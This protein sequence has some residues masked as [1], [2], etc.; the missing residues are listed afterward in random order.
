MKKADV[1]AKLDLYKDRPVEVAINGA[2]D[3]TVYGNMEGRWLFDGGDFLIAVATN[4]PNGRF[5][6]GGTS[7]REMPF[8][9]IN[10][11]YDD[12]VYV[13]SFIK[14]NEVTD[15]IS[16]LTPV[17]TDKSID[18]IV[19]EISTSSIMKANSPRGYVQ[20]NYNK[21]NGPYG[22]FRG[23]A[24]STEIDGLPKDIKDLANKE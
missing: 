20:A 11:D 4:T 18:D 15:T 7:Q 12:V 22:R 2:G 9:I 3:I 21:P 17:G 13:K 1:I 23:S 8:T 16:A 19:K 14:Y 5:D 10:I 6:L 24:V